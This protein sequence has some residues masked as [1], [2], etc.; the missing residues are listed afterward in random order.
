[1]GPT[2]PP[3]LWVLGAFSRGVKRPGREADYSPTPSAE[4]KN[5]GAIPLLPHTS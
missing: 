3:E 5:S 2:Q 4:V 1:M